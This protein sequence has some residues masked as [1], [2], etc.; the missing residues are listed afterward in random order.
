MAGAAAALHPRMARALPRGRVITLLKPPA[1]RSA[2]RPPLSRPRR[3]RR[4]PWLVLAA[5]A[6]LPVVLLAGAGDQCDTGSTGG[7]PDVGGG[8]GFE[9]TAY[10]PP[11]NAENGTGQTAFGP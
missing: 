1:A 5:L 10:G 3:S 9:E 4:W 2:R 11:W 8:R 7:G 6:L